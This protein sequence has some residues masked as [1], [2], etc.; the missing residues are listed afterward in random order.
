MI[1]T[2]TSFMPTRIWALAGGGTDC[3]WL[4]MEAETVAPSD[5]ASAHRNEDLLRRFIA[6]VYAILFTFKRLQQ[7]FRHRSPT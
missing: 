1:G 2:I 3:V 7:R 4:S 6:A 5:N